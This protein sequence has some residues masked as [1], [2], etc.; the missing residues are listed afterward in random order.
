METITTLNNAI[1]KC[2]VDNVL[3]TILL[4]AFSVYSIILFV[5][6]LTLSGS[7]SFKRN[8]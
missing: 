7:L 4:V 3:L 6:I 5:A 2:I 8:I 1:K